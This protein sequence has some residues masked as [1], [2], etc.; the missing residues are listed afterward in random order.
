MLTPEY[1]QQ[2]TEG[3][4][5][6]ASTLHAIIMNKIISRMI[7][8]LGRGEE[9]LLTATDKW[10]IEV[11]QE[12]G[13]LLEEIQQEIARITSLQTD[14]IREAMEEAGVKS[15]DYDDKIYKSAGIE[16]SDPLQS[17]GIMRILERDYKATSAEWKNFTRTTAQEAQKAFIN[18]TDKAY[19]LAISGA[20]SY[21][22]AV[23]DAINEVS[24]DG[25]KVK[26][27]S[28]RELTIESA[29][30]MIVRTGISQASAEIG[31]ARMDEVDCDLVI[32]S[33]HL[34]ARPSHQKW[35]GKIYSRSG[36]SKKYPDFVR[37]TG[38]GKVDGLCGA[39]C[40]H[41]FSPYFE[42][43]SKNPFEKYDSKENKKAYEIQQ[44]QRTLERRVRDTKRQVQN[45][46]TAVDG[47]K[48]DQ[49]REKLQGV[50]DKKSYLLKTQNSEYNK[51]C[52]ENNLKKYNERLQI[53]KWDR[54]QA[55]KAAGA[56]KRYE[57][58]K[59]D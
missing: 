12:A 54:K 27:S 14:E 29:T 8:R 3:A 9:Y 35:Q 1:L 26:Y 58:A 53:A 23:K 7:A 50:L 45:L 36:K 38:Y 55:M 49:A 19:R 39:N 48:D 24:R 51:Y 31:V 13:F 10:Q 52:E 22:E 37:S 15:L 32:V 41:N 21:S 16:V 20:V 47:C 6:L 46:Q 42:G 11:L 30:S 57:N 4:E 56:A 5:D 2:V 34:G 18:A 43:I 40:R 59:G 25:I 28:G 33:S 17:P 44:R